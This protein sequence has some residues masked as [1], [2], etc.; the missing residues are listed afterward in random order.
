ML[1]TVLFQAEHSSA[2]CI[3]TRQSDQLHKPFVALSCFQKGV[4]H[5]SIR[6]FNALSRSL[7]KLKTDL[8]I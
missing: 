1:A 5:L 4:R 3:K 2:H 8:K 6:I 7:V